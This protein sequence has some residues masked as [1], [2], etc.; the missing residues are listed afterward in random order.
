MKLLEEAGLPP[1]VINFVPGKGA[2]V[3]DPV[4]AS[5]RLRRP[6]LH[7]LDGDLPGDVADD[8][9]KP[10]GATAATRASSARPAAR[11][12][13]SP[14][15]RPTLT[16]ADRRHR[17]RRLRVPGAEVLRRLARLHP[18]VALGRG[19]AESLEAQ[20][21]GDHR[22]ARPL[23]FRNF[24]CAVIDESAFDDIS[25]YIDEAKNDARLPRSSPA[26]AA[27]TRRA[28]SSSRPSSPAR[29]PG[30]A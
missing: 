4:F 28:T 27:T 6:P 19:S 30:H 24:M 14:T 7:R 9:R 12:S 3:G 15:R 13:S 1:G 11:T 2:Q 20:V 22:W 21:D 29:I 5:E 8:R 25:G 18:Q 16:R 23:D 17:A 10:A 26:A